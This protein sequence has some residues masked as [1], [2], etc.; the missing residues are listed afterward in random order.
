M[1]ILSGEQ[2]RQWDAY[3]ITNEPITSEQLMFRASMTFVNWFIE[4]FPDVDQPIY[5][6]CGTGNNGGDGLVIANQLHRRFY[7]VHI[8]HCEVS[9]KNSPDFNYYF[10]KLPKK[11]ELV[12][13]TIQKEDTFPPIPSNAIAIDALFGTGL[14]KAVEGYWAQLIN[15]LNQNA[16]TKI[17]VDMPSGVFADQPTDS[18]SIQADYT[19][20]FERPKLAFFLAENESRIGEWE[21]API[22][23]KP[24]FLSKVKSSYHA[25]DFNKAASLVRGRNK[26]SHKG[27][28][29]HCMIIA[30]SHGKVGAAILSAK[31]CLR[32][33]TGLVTIHA[34]ECAYPI[35]QSN[36]PEAMVSVDWHS[37]YISGVPE[38]DKYDSIGVGCGIDTREN[39]VIVLEKLLSN[40]NQPLVLDADALNIISQQAHLLKQV[41]KNSILTPHPGEFK[42]LFGEQANDFER[43]EVLQKTAQEYEIYIV[44]KGANTCIACPDGNL[45]FN[46]TGNPGMATAGSGDV[47]TGI[48]SGFLAQGYSSQ[49]AALL[50]V[51]LHGLAGDIAVEDLS[52]WEALIAGDIVE[53]L[54]EAFRM[55]K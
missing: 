49:D 54:G 27:T 31:A 25:L 10:H 33:G 13:H 26:F 14:N 45:Y 43:L 46:T 3:T 11:Q 36:I 28:F 40:Y 32:S 55:M 18:I 29:G 5:I 35:L 12:I 16:S 38:V 34:P 44:L 50:G 37:Y 19:F 30:G 51:Y 15:H 47:L 2:T 4:K 20:S 9:P 22:G 21:V 24:S 23:L 8:F 6:F 7:K 48:I 52:S 1:Q 42:R 39:T 41:P 17:A 53:H